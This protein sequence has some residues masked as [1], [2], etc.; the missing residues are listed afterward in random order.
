VGVVP[1]DGKPSRTRGGKGIFKSTREKK[2]VLRV[3]FI[4]NR[5]GPGGEFCF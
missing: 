2:R 4:K 3:F 5:R 1:G